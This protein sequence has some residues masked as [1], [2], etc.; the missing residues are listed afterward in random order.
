M[1][2]EEYRAEIEKPARKKGVAPVQQMLGLLLSVLL[3]WAVFAPPAGQGGPASALPA[4]PEPRVASTSPAISDSLVELGLAAHVVGRSG[5]C[6]SLPSTVPV[7]GDLRSF[8]AERLALARPSVLFVQPPLAGVDPALA[9]FC[10][11]RGIEI[12]A[13]PLDRLADL[14]RMAAVIERVFATV[15][16]NGAPTWRARLEEIKTSIASAPALPAQADRVLLVV[17]A[18][19]FLAVGRGN[20][21]DELLARAGYANAVDAA[22]WVELSAEMMVALAPARAVAISETRAGAL[23]IANAL[24][25][26][27]WRGPAPGI[28]AEAIP[29]L[30]SPSFAA[31]S[32]EADLARLLSQAGEARQSGASAP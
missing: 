21:L 32:H 1:T 19:P 12:V 14:A 3:I 13:Q 30:L 23:E 27:P 26:L 7:V 5:Y 15:Q 22:G 9:E 24:E 16:G 20:Y 11:A 10:R 18:E 2:G 29:A 4:A 6:R 25:V 28:A 31:L 8:D 17:S